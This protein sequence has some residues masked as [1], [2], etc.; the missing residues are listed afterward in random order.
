MGQSLA[1]DRAADDGKGRADVLADAGGHQRQ[2]AHAHGVEHHR[3]AG[4]DAAADHEELLQGGHAAH[5]VIAHAEKQDEQQRHGDHHQYLR[6]GGHDGIDGQA[7]FDGSVDGEHQRQ[8]DGHIGDAAKAGGGQD[9]AHD[10]DGDD[11]EMP[12]GQLLLEDHRAQGEH[13]QGLDIVAQAALQHPAVLHGP[14]VHQP[15]AEQE[16]GGGDLPLQHLLVPEHSP[17]LGQL[18]LH[19]Q[20]AQT[21]DGGPGDAAGHEEEGVDL[22]A[23]GRTHI[24]VQRLEAPYQKARG[25]GGQA[26]SVIHSLHI[27]FLA[28]RPKIGRKPHLQLGITMI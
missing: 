3:Q 28:F 6:G 11:D 27:Y 13:H 4:D 24:P 8:G 26:L 10:D 9:D 25:H 15:V 19:L 22:A 12:P 23:E 20:D 21:A 2:V 14:K 5:T 1:H 17:Q 18:A 16:Y 7:L